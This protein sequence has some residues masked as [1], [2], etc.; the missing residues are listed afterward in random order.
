[1]EL[2]FQDRWIAVVA[3]PAGLP[4]QAG[5]DGDPGAY[6]RLQAAHPYVG[7]HHRLDRP[8]SG[9]VLF[10]LHK[11][12]NKPV[13]RALRA[14]LIH[15]RYRAVLYGDAPGGAWEWRV[16]GKPARTT[17]TRVGYGHGTTAVELVLHTGRTHQIRVHAA[18]SGAPVL[19]DRRYGAESGRAWPRLALH[20]W[21]LAL[22]HPMTGE[23]LELTAPLPADLA[24]AW[25]RAGG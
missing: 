11:A 10:T 7:L 8:A 1:M 18:M 2:V 14:G 22:A 16:D 24:E 3:K 25:E 15:R 23:P 4:T 12:A 9:L 5:R 19:G 21:R 6:E 17:C 13:S 20:A